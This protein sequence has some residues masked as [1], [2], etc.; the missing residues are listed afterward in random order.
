MYVLW[1]ASFQNVHLEEATN[2]PAALLTLST[3]IPLH[4]S[5]SY[6][7]PLLMRLPHSVG[8]TRLW[9]AAVVVEGDQLMPHKEK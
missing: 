5:S 9:A 1:G 3:T 6:H 2:T 4:D 7:S 8:C